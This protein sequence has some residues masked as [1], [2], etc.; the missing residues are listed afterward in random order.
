MEK[1]F[2]TG[3]AGFIG[4]HL[5]QSLAQEGYEVIGIDNLNSYYDVKF[6]YSRL[7]QLCGIK[8]DCVP[9][10]ENESAI[11]PGC[12][13]MFGDITDKQSLLALFEKHQFS[14]VCHLAAQAGV[15]Y[16]L[17]NP[18]AYIKSNVI[19]F[20]NIL[21]ACR[22]HPVKHLIYASSSSVY[23][24][25]VKMPSSEKDITDKPISLYAATKRTGELLAYTYSH[26]YKIPS[27]GLRFFTVYGPWGRP[28]MAPIIFMD[29]IV[30]GKIIHIYNYGKMMR[31]FTYISDI[32]AV[33]QRI[34]TNGPKK[35]YNIYNVGRSHPVQLMDLVHGIERVTHRKAIC[36]FE[37]KQQG[38]VLSTYANTSLLLQDYGY[39]PNIDLNE[40]LTK[41]FEWYSR[42]IMPKQSPIHLGSN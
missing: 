9:W 39:H 24:D 32:I 33:I 26:L 21:E 2:V 5:F 28:D 17:T 4:S 20:L 40:G 35:M 1:V 12:A 37:Q 25:S 7:N 31:D 18:E 6:K 41:T 27:T 10:I 19:G 38:D 16:S 29:S 36:H 42:Y 13:F 14:I 34:M 30:K 8:A 15:R 23:G 11:Y 3:A 22:F